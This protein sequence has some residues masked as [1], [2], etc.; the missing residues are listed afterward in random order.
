VYDA[1]VLHGGGG[2]VR[3]DLRVKVFKFLDETDAPGQANNRQ[4]DTDTYR[5]WEIAGTS[6]L[7]AQ[8]SRALAGVGLRV[9]GMTPVE[10]SPPVDGP[11]ISG[12][13]G[14]GGAGNGDGQSNVGPNGGCEK[15]PFSRIPSHYALD[16]AF[17]HV[18]RWVK[19]GTAPPT[20]P[21]IDLKEAPPGD[22]PAGRGGPGGRRGA[23]AGP[24]WVV[25]RDESG[26]ALGGIRLSQHAV[27]TATNTGAKTGGQAGGER[28][29]GLMGSYEPFDAAR[30]ATLYPTHAAY[31]SKVKDVTARNVKAGYIVKADADATV[32]EAERSDVGRLKTTRTGGSGPAG[33]Q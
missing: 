3:P 31:V 15:P 11:T 2:K 7:N 27:P 10:G 12:G 1:V 14:N 21:P 17:D 23:P 16:A 20:A 13:A 5:Q 24:R 9:S 29:C 30:L 26:N 32:A 22:A 8:F 28:N 19:D 18:A 25:V 33:I 6:H 4:S